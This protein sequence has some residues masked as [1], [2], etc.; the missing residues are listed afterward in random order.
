MRE[1][2][3][4]DGWTITHDPYPIEVGEVPM[5]IDLAAEKTIAAER[6]DSKIVVEIKSFLGPSLI[7]DFHEAT[8]QYR[9]YKSAL[10]EKDPS[11]ILFLAV[12]DEVFYDFFQRPFVQKRLLEDRIHLLIFNAETNQIES[13]IN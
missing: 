3:E 12:S 10:D 1:A 9:N 11:R 2:L 6:G 7:Y 13:W 4:K 8:G 5:R